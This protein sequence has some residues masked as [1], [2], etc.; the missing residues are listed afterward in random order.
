MATTVDVYGSIHYSRSPQ[1]AVNVYAEGA[2]E[3]PHG[4]GYLVPGPE[5]SGY[6]VSTQMEMPFA[7]ARAQKPKGQEP[8]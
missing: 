6:F 5:S 2:A 7:A 8:S 4:F 3:R 1:L